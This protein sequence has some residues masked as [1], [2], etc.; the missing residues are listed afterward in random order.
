[1]TESKAAEPAV[2]GAGM[3]EPFTIRETDLRR[4]N[5]QSG[6]VYDLC[7]VALE[8]LGAEGIGYRDRKNLETVIDAIKDRNTEIF[9]MTISIRMD[10]ELGRR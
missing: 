4:L 10:R 3:T 7:H 6:L 5:T 2:T 8:L 1:M 9:Q